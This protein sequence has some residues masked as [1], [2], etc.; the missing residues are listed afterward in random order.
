MAVRA[1][2]YR[3]IPFNYT[4]ADDA[5]VVALL[6]GDGT[7]ARLEELRARRV[8]GRSARLLMRFLG[9]VFIHRRNAYLF[10]E[11]LA[12]PKRQAKLL[13][14]LEADLG[15]IEAKAAGRKVVGYGAPGK[16]NT[17]LNYCG[18]RSDFLDF[19]VD[20]NPYKQGKFTPGTRIPILAPE[21]LRQ[22]RPD[23]VLILP[24]NLK[25]EIVE[26]MAHVR[27]WGGRFVVPIPEVKVL[28]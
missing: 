6:L 23:E 17:L 15:D 16:G 3:E 12:S 19:T 11:L 27:G 4:S 14:G 20:A 28:P 21:A 2:G 1:T 18:I 8:T 5:R 9:E 24:W 25:D 13:G 22:A 26:Q 10:E 7:W